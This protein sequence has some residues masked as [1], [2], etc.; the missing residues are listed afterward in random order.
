[1][2]FVDESVVTKAPVGAAGPPREETVRTKHELGR[3]GYGSAGQVA[4]GRSQEQV[5][6]AS[7]NRGTSS[8]DLQSLPG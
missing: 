1:M 6:A 5:L 8:K 2:L 7:F 4:R 3:L